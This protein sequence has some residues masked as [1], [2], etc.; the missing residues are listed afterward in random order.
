MPITSVQ[1]FLEQAEK[2]GKSLGEIMIEHE[3]S[4][5]DVSKKD[6]LA[7]MEKIWKVME[8]SIEKGVQITEKSPSGMS[9]GDARKLLTWSKNK[10][11][12]TNKHILTAVARAIAVGEYNSSMGTIVAAPTAGSAGVIPATVYSAAE[13]FKASKDDILSSLFAASLIGLVCDANAS[14]S[15]SEHGCQAEIGVAAAMGACAVVELAGGSP[16]QAINAAALALKN[17]LG[18]AC[19]P[20]A[21]LVEVPCIKRN[22]VFTAEALIA[23]DLSLA[24]ITSIIPFDDVVAA[25]DEIGRMMPCEIKETSEGGLATT[26][27]GR[28]YKMWLRSSGDR[29]LVK[30]DD[31]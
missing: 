24:G 4:L 3:L 25:M 11:I 6:V 28:G 20:V 5:H 10:K 30:V 26:K 9:G 19:D 14:T 8:S 22:G 23:A 13:K 18:L 29:R 1:P 7:A 21:G 15:G 16:T 27:T 12:V 17:T 31:E 2:E